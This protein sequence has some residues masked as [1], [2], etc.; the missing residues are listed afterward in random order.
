MYTE[1]AVGDVD[2][3]LAADGGNSRHLAVVVAEHGA[4]LNKMA[5]SM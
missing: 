2:V 5:L 1:G 3:H 4:W